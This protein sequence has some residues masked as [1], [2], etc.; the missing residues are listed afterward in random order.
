[1][2]EYKSEKPFSEEWEREMMKWNKK[3]LIGRLETCFKERIKVR[4]ILRKMGNVHG[5]ENLESYLS[6][7]FAELFRELQDVFEYYPQN[8]NQ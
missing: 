3:Q 8:T 1:M 7:E 4:Q 2:E 6:E 5:V